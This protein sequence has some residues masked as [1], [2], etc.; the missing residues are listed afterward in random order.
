MSW[1]T[2]EW[3]QQVIRDDFQ[4]RQKNP[5]TKMLSGVRSVQGGG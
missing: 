2:Q 4:K 3:K 1:A 5:N